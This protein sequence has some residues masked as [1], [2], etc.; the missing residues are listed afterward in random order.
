MSFLISSQRT[1]ER[2]ALSEAYYLISDV[3]NYKVQPLNS[4]VPGLS[5]LTLVEDE[6]KVFQII[7]EIQKYIEEK[8]PLVA[9]LKIVPLEKVI[10]TNITL[11]NETALSL[12]KTKIS[13]TD[14]WRI[15]VKKRQT[16]L[17]TAEIIECIA[18]KIN[19]G[20]VNLKSPKYEIRVEIIRNLTG[21]T[22]MT[23]DFEI[24][25]SK[26]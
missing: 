10:K 22:V 11:I 5:I 14:S 1:F 9:C 16:N 4:H 7:R 15:T 26:Y 25:M 8:G 6:K 3:L 24:R 19:W 12:A 23:P 21:I 17:R 13:K 18:N 20:E 2:D